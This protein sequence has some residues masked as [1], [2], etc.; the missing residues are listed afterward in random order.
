MP[1]LVPPM[2][3]LW[4]GV[5]TFAMLL[6][7]DGTLVLLSELEAVWSPRFFASQRA[8]GGCFAGF[9]A[10]LTNALSRDEITIINALSDAGKADQYARLSVTLLP[11]A[12]ELVALPR[13]SA[14]AAIA[15]SRAF[16]RA[17]AAAGALTI[18]V[19]EVLTVIPH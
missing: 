11:T 13:S 2:V 16:T 1:M 17:V 7:P 5:V 18:S 15:L 12:P 6:S 19:H 14:S 9:E 4:F 3:P 8:A 10:L